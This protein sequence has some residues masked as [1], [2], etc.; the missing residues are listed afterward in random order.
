MNYLKTNKVAWNKRTKIHIH[1]RFYNV[2]GELEYQLK[3]SFPNPGDEEK[4][5]E[6]FKTDPELDRMGIDVYLQN[7]ELSLA[8]PTLVVVEEKLI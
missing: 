3:A 8:M 7:N 6:M 2:N 4:I 5:R 1:S